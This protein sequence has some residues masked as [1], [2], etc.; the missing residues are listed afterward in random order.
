MQLDHMLGFSGKYNSTVIA[1]PQDDSIYIKSMGSLVVVGDIDDVHK[2]LFLRGHDM[3]ITSLAASPS[4]RFLASGQKGTVH[5]RGYAAPVFLWD[6]TTGERVSVLRGITEAVE[7]L[8]F[9]DDEKFLCGAGADSLLYIWD[10]AT[11]EVVFGTRLTQPAAVVAWVN[12]TTFH[13]RTSYELAIGSGSLLN[14][15]IFSFE[16]LRVQWQLKIEPYNM[17][18]QGGL[19]RQF[20]DMAVS[21][22]RIFIYVGTMQGEMMVFRRDTA[23]FRALIP[24]CSNGLTGI[25]VQANGDILCGGGDGSLKRLRGM[26][27]EWQVLLERY[28]KGPIASVNLSAND[29]EA[30]V[31]CLNGSVYR[32]L[33]E[34]LSEGTVS[35][36]HTDAVTCIHFNTRAPSTFVTGTVGASIKVWEVADYAC[37][38][39][40]T[41]P[42]YGVVMSLTMLA[43]SS[44]VSGWEDGNIRCHDATLSR[45]KWIIAGAHRGGVS[46]LASYEDGNIGFVLSG[47][48]DGGVR[49]WRSTT[50][51][52][53]AEYT[54]H[55]KPVT[56]VLVDVQRPNLVHS[57]SLDASVVT[58]DI[59]AQQRVQTHIS[60]M[61]VIVDMTQRLDGETEL[62][63]ADN[64]GKL[65]HWDVDIREPVLAVQDPTRVALSCCQVSPSGRFLAFAGEDTLLKVLDLRSGQVT[66]L[67]QGHSATIRSLHWT[68][69]E[70]QILTGGNDT[71]LCVWNFFLGGDAGADSG[72]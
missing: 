3:V 17:P 50:R 2:Q 69:D 56:K 67:G 8:C 61:G 55:A 30:I 71:C 38:A 57:C 65:L 5:F 40:L 52:F 29:T 66:S 47:G 11:G 49:V 64:S 70:R 27:M 36:A 12:S 58:Y 33:V 59:R 4:G 31:G 37:L 35:Q 13:G 48:Q 16:Q 68:P 41:C 60:N 43:D 34:N 24:V 21:P 53:V 9:S 1:H 19:V 51:E 7:C 42:K 10:L 25:A 46:S 63:T 39:E 45:E 15:A 26:D 54:D 14:K 18:V 44:I 72:Q 6:L 22:D 28:I 32:C 23:V 62:I 20:L